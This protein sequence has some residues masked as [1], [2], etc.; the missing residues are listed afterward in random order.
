MKE[1]LASPLVI[2]QTKMIK[3]SNTKGIRKS[4]N[5]KRVNE[6][7][8]SFTPHLHHIHTHTPSHHSHH[9][10]HHTLIHFHS[11]FFT[12]HSTSLPSI[13]L[14]IIHTHSS[15]HPFHPFKPISLHSFSR[16]FFAVY[17]DHSNSGDHFTLFRS[18]SFHPFYFLSS[19]CMELEVIRRRGSD[20]R[21]YQ[22]VKR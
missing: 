2:V 11:H 4:Q 3:S 21:C 22:S 14:I 20:G 1:M 10:I 13:T 6:I 12:T 8:P 9:I 16:Y 15:T 17:R 19:S 18:N 7:A 5:N